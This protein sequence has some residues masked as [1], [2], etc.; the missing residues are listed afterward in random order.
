MLLIYC[1]NQLKK[2]ITP[3]SKTSEGGTLLPPSDVNVRSFLCP[4]SVYKTRL[5]ESSRVIK[6][7]PWSQSQIFF[8]RDH[9][10]D[11]VHCKL[12]KGMTE[13]EMVGWHQRL[14]GHKFEQPPGDGEEQGSLVCCSPLGCKESD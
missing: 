13:D 4:F 11:I 1:N 10:S 7:G 3:F 14:N 6:P 5:H 8:L 12:S 9:K 2:Y